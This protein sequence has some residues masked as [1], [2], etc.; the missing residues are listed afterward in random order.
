[1]P[2]LKPI[3]QSNPS[4]SVPSPE[5]GEGQGGGDGSAR[6][7]FR[8]RE[9]PPPQPSPIL[10]K[11]VIDQSSGALSFSTRGGFGG[12]GLIARATLVMKCSWPRSNS[13][14]KLSAMA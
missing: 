1:M 9:Q 14:G 2:Q 10:G 12:G 8:R 3:T 6:L 7:S 11:G 5:A 4:H 13:S